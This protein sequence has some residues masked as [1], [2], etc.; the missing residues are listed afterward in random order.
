MSAQPIDEQPHTPERPS[1]SNSIHQTSILMESPR[2]RRQRQINDL[3]EEFYRF[4]NPHSVAESLNIDEQAYVSPIYEYW[5]LK[6]RVCDFLFFVCEYYFSIFL[7]FISF[8]LSFLQSNKN[9]PLLTSR[10]DEA[11]MIDRQEEEACRRRAKM[12]IQ[13]RH[14]LESVLIFHC[15]FS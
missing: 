1:S 10:E 15:R 13:L 9:A 14:N 8:F 7:I 11:E 6:R 3:L 2:R 5:K 12:L 4:T